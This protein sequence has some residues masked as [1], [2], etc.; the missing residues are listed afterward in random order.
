MSAGHGGARIAVSAIIVI[1]IL[2][3]GTGL[4]LI[5]IEM[6]TGPGNTTTTTTTTTDPI[7]T[8]PTTTTP[9]GP[10]HN[11]Y[12][13]AIVFTTG[14]LGDSGF[15]DACYIG[16]ANAQA[17]HNINFTYAEPVSIS[18]YETFLRSFSEH[19]GYIEQ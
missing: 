7:T 1:G 15:N 17:D 3:V 4:F 11:P 8:S 19:A 2:L 9:T 18:D 14:G 12:E 10:V 5:V 13:V 6:P 16:A